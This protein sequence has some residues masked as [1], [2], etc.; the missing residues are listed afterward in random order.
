MLS[1]LTSWHR[2]RGLSKLWVKF[3]RASIIRLLS[4]IIIIGR[5]ISIIMAQRLRMERMERILRTVVI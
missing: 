3:N 2:L 4:F 5:F 1:L